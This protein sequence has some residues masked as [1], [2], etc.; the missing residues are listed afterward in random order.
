MSTSLLKHISA[1]GLNFEVEKYGIRVMN[2]NISDSLILFFDSVI[3]FKF[4]CI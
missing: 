4:S 2:A 1:A 3:S